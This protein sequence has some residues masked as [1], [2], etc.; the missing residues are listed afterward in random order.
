MRKFV[1]SL[2]L[3]IPFITAF[4]QEG[5]YKGKIGGKY[6]VVKVLTML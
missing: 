6:A 1:F 5:V 4:S 2:L 3:A